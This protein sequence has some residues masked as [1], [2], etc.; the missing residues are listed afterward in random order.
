MQHLEIILISKP[1]DIQANT[2]LKNLLETYVHKLTQTI[3]KNSFGQSNYADTL[4]IPTC[5]KYVSI[6]VN[7]Q[8]NRAASSSNR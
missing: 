4:A 3:T 6:L 5:N 2:T 8:S 1:Q 7:C